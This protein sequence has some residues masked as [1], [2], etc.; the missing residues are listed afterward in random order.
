MLHVTVLTMPVLG[1]PVQEELRLRRER[2]ASAMLPLLL[3]V[4]SSSTLFLHAST[5]SLSLDVDCHMS[6]E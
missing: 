3:G 2:R 5:G 1:L 4:A 6:E